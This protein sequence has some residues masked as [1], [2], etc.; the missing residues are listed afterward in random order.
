MKQLFVISAIET[1][2]HFPFMADVGHWIIILRRWSLRQVRIQMSLMN[3]SQA[4]SHCYVWVGARLTNLSFLHVA[5]FARLATW[6]YCFLRLS[7]VSGLSPGVWDRTWLNCSG[8]SFSRFPCD[9]H[10]NKNQARC[11][12]NNGTGDGPR[13]REGE[14]WL[15]FW[16][17]SLKTRQSVI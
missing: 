2:F 12:A 4:W 13:A 8:R 7:L 5:L 9:H 17:Q 11:L 6:T 1:S 15:E 3:V 14:I 16:Y 10:R